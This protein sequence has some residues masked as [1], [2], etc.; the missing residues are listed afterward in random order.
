MKRH[1]RLLALIAGSA[2]ALAGSGYTQVSAATAQSA[3]AQKKAAKKAAK[4]MT[5]VT[6]GT[7]KSIND[8]QLVVEK[9]AKKGSKDTTFVL[10][11][12]TQKQGDLKVGSPVTVHY[13]LENKQD[14]ATL[15]KAAKK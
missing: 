10:N 5:S 12:E 9:K 14:V 1:N 7:I 6:R 15:V 2:L 3:P 8:S 13:R 4:S 11:S